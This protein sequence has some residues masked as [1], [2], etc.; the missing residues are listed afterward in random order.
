[1]SL[2]CRGNQ[3]R[4]VGQRFPLGRGWRPV[5]GREQKKSRK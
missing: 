5:G 1:M 2:T 4:K 3:D